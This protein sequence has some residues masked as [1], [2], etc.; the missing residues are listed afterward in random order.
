MMLSVSWQF[1]CVFPITRGPQVKSQPGEDSW[2][3]APM[4]TH[5]LIQTAHPTGPA[6]PD[7]AP[8]A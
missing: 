1:Y 4:S 3:L 8:A 6:S 7:P 5:A 2:G